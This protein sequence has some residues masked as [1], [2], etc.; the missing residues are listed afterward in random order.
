[1]KVN[2]QAGVWAVIH[3]NATGAFLFGKRSSLVNALR[4]ATSCATSRSESR[5]S[6]S[7]SLLAVPGLPPEAM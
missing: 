1:M 4:K 5:R 7:S 6:T 3:C 2:K